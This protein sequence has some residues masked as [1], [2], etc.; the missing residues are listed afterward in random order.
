MSLKE[1]DNWLM[2]AEH[3]GSRAPEDLDDLDTPAWRG[4]DVRTHGPTERR[5]IEELH[6]RGIRSLTYLNLGYQFASDWR[7]GEIPD[8]VVIDQL[9]RPQLQP[10]YFR[11][12][13]KLVYELCFNVRKT[14]DGLLK[15][16]EEIMKRGGDGLFL[17]NAGPA[18]RCWGPQ[19]G[20]DDHPQDFPRQDGAHRAGEMTLECTACRCMK[21][22][23]GLR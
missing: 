22:H 1:H 16:A 11:R 13:G 23:A 15:R 8:T 5:S 19:F 7:A 9:G 17:D 14:R 2:T 21:G 6:R 10:N 20:R 18:R 3:I 12:D 4:Y